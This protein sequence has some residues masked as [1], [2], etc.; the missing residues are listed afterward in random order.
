MEVYLELPP[1]GK[2]TDGSGLTVTYFWRSHFLSLVDRLRL[3]FLERCGIGLLFVS[4]V[5]GLIGNLVYFPIW[6]IDRGLSM[7]AL[8]AYVTVPPL[9]YILERVLPGAGVVGFLAIVLIEAGRERSQRSFGSWWNRERLALASVVGAGAVD[10][11]SIPISGTYF[12]TGLDPWMLLRSLLSIVVV[13]GTSLYLFWTAERFGRTFT[14]ALGSVALS[15]AVASAGLNPFWYPGRW[16]LDALVDV[17]ALSIS[18]SV[19]GATLA[20]LS[21]VLWIVAYAGV[22]PWSPV[23]RPPASVA[24]EV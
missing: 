2:V 9:Q 12:V 5:L 4:L 22:L 16:I 10:L 6:T 1:V 21:L 15:L 14:R 17:R 11:S 24:S 20:V 19:A 18:L 13:T 8:L 7:R 23:A 3:R